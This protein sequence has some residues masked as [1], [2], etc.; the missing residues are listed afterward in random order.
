MSIAKHSWHDYKMSL[1][2]SLANELVD[3]WDEDTPLRETR[4]HPYPTYNKMEE[5]Q[6]T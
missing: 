6:T 5:M 4:T 1:S 3:H 2:P